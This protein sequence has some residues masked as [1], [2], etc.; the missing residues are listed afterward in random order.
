MHLNDDNRRL[1]DDGIN[2]PRG[3]GH[4]LKR[5]ERGPRENNRRPRNNKHGLKYDG[6]GPR[7]DGSRV[8]RDNP[9]R[10]IDE[11]ISK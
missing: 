4:G 3:D 2:G 9:S 7:G 8:P 11:S 10:R 5:N 1:L 6:R